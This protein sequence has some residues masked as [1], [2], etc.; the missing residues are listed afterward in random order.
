MVTSVAPQVPSG[1]QAWSPSQIMPGRQSA[2][3]AQ[4]PSGI[5]VSL[6]LQ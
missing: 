1:T 5:Q 3:T 6:A 2:S 4:V